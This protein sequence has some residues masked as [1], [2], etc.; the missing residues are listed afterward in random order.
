MTWTK[1]IAVNIVLN[2]ILFYV[3]GRWLRGH[4]TGVRVPY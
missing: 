2:A 1:T 3:I 4:R